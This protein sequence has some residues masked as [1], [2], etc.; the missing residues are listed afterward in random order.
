MPLIREPQIW[1]AQKRRLDGN[2]CPHCGREIRWVYDGYDWIAVDPEPVMFIMH[3][4]G[5]ST[6]VYRNQP[7]EHCIIYRKGDKRFPAHPL[8]GR[9]RH[10]DTCPTLKASRREYA[11]AR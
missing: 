5:K 3:P 4:E 8:S 7:V 9:T 2:V 11:M 6:L 1:P 10:Y